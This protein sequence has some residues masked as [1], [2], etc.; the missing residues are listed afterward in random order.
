MYEGFIDHSIAVVKIHV[1]CVLNGC[2]IVLFKL[3]EEVYKGQD[4]YGLHGFPP[5]LSSPDFTCQ[6]V[7]NFFYKRP[8][9]IQSNSCISLTHKTVYLIPD[10]AFCHHIVKLDV[11]L[12]KRG[13]TL[14]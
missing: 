3:C 2:L 14:I 12:L 11:F 4:F 9:R 6:R 8:I 7:A 1:Y 13:P 5:L 10:F